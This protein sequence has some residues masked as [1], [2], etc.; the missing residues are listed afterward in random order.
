[1][2]ILNILYYYGVPEVAGGGV[3]NVAHY[4]PLALRKK[5]NVTCLRGIKSTKGFPEDYLDI[6]TKFVKMDFDIIHFNT[7]PAWKNGSS[8][9]M[10]FAKLRHTNTVLNIHGIPQLAWKAEQRR[11]SDSASFSFWFPTLIYCKFVD[12]IVVN[13]EYMRNNVVFWYKVN[14]DKVAVI[15]NGVDVQMFV[16]NNERMMLEGDPSILYVGQLSKLKGLDILIQAI[17]KLRSEFPNIKLHIVGGGSGSYFVAQAKKE[18]IEKNLI[19]HGLT[20]HSILPTYYKSAD[21]C[22]FPSR[23]EGFG[24]VILEAM[25]SGIPVIASDIPSFRETISDGIDGE[26]FKAG[27][28]DALSNKISALIQNPYLRKELSRKAFEKAKS[29]SWENVA[30][31][32]VSLYKSLR[33]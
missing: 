7:N 3:G 2:I 5:V 21:I 23:H 28:A 18:G 4:L 12:Q 31:K 30:D 24:I 13:S 33:E 11:V 25:A 9:L 22:I 27:D 6:F 14:R 29:Y 1:L 15:P 10:R 32:Y 19:F 20:L 16:D 17:A 8:I 26:L